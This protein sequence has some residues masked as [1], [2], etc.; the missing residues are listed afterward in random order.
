VDVPNIF[1]LENTEKPF[2]QMEPIDRALDIS[3]SKLAPHA[4]LI[5]PVKANLHVVLALS[6]VGEIVWRRSG[7]F[8]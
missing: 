7:M 1:P 4:I 3:M 8:P 5:S 2:G 6:P